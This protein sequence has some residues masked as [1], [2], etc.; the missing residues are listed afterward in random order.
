M[1]IRHISNVYTTNSSM[2]NK[3]NPAK[4]KPA[5]SAAPKLPSFDDLERAG[6]AAVQRICAE[7]GI[8]RAEVIRRAKEDIRSPRK[9]PLPR[10][11][12]IRF[13]ETL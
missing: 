6:N 1:S 4:R 7:L 10:G 3:R 13:K 5:K 9:I 8:D 12:Q 2:T 11:L